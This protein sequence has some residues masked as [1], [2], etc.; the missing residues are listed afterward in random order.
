MLDARAWRI[1]LRTYWSAQGWRVPRAEPSA[2]DREYASRA[3]YLF[4]TESF[5]HDQAVRRI[6]AA[7][8]GSNLT[9]LTA[10]FVASLSSRLVHLRPGLP[11]YFLAGAV[12]PHTLGGLTRC[13]VCGMFPT[14]ERDFG[15]VSF[16]RYK[17]GSF[18][19]PSRSITPSSSSEWQPSQR[20]SQ[21][22]TTVQR[23]SRS[24]C[25]CFPTR[26]ARRTTWPRW[27]SSWRRIGKS[28]A[29][30]GVVVV[31]GVLSPRGLPSRTSGEFRRGRTVRPGALWRG[32][33]RIDDARF[34]RSSTRS[35]PAT[36]RRRFRALAEWAL[37][38]AGGLARW[39]TIT[40]QWRSQRS[41]RSHRTTGPVSSR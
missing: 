17:W 41:S 22:P 8:S 10:C 19:S 23:S 21:P 1:L 35:A 36:S 39:A 2:E 30:V 40:G 38:S 9:S 31:L 33:H 13:S 4:D 18:S 12:E 24:G 25:G 3:G 28:A 15:S 37:A 14:F 27:R 6:A 7:V 16:A 26:G 32:A 11:S 34:G 29:S 20:C 5:S